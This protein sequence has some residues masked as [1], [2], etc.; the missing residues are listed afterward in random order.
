MRQNRRTSDSR[1]ALRQGFTLIE[2]LVVIAIIAILV[3]LLLPAVQSAREAARRTQ[4][5]NNLKQIGLALHNHADAHG[6]FPPGYVCYDETANRFKVGGW[7]DTV[8]EIG[9]SWLPMLL[10]YVEQMGLW[11][12]VSDCHDSRVDVHEHN[13]SDDCEYHAKFGHVGRKTPEFLQCPSNPTPSL[14]FSGMSLESL[15]KGNYAASWGSGNMLSWEST[16]TVGAFACHFVNQNKIVKGLGGSGDRFQHS[17]GTRIADITDGTSN[18]VAVSEVAATDGMS[19]TSSRDVRG[20][21]F[22]PGM[23]ASVFSGARVPNARIPD[24]IPSCDTS[25][26]DNS[27]PYLKCQE[28]TTTA[29]V[30]AA[31]RSFHT[32]GVNSLLCDGSVRFFAENIDNTT[33]MSL[34]TRQNGENIGEF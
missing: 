20:V 4:C 28:N 34:N 23:G 19:G 21:W 3:A 29:D 14:L 18:T 12:N 8:N 31:S 26:P 2:L 17:M 16:A 30:F 11:Q 24:V 22:N 32:G 1:Q 33:W 6:A 25:I 15:S 13:P 10:P 5:K 27:Q 7:Q 9:F